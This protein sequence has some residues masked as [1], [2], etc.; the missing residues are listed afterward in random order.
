[1]SVAF[2]EFA[3]LPPGMSE[4]MAPSQA[5]TMIYQHAAALYTASYDKEKKLFR[6][7]PDQAA[8]QAMLVFN[9]SFDHGLL[10]HRAAACANAS[11]ERNVYQELVAVH[12]A[13][14]WA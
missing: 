1:M 6:L 7:T 10:L 3:A 4:T 13:N 14:I 8:T 2:E 5:A 12:A 9:T 11:G